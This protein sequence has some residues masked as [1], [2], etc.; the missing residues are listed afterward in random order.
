MTN[1]SDWSDSFEEMCRIGNLKA[2]RSFVS[3][4][5]V[6]S[7]YINGNSI[8]PIACRHGQL[9]VAEWF[10]KAFRLSVRSWIG[11]FSEACAVND[12][13]IIK[14]LVTKFNY[15]KQEYRKELLIH[16]GFATS[17]VLI[18][19]CIAHFQ[20]TRR[21]ICQ[22]NSLAEIM[23]REGELTVFHW[24]VITFEPSK[25]MI[26]AF[27]KSSFEAL[28][29]SGHEKVLQWLVDRYYLLPADVGR[30]YTHVNFDPSRKPMTDDEALE[31]MQVMPKW[32]IMR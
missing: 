4:Y 22:F 30:S 15:T 1:R 18:K 5:G 23:L 7:C 11:G 8:F 13:R 9:E 20:Y 19:W 21:E 29:Q 28:C 2:I 26:R 14:W 25:E 12:L 31:A 3:L 27:H 16:I 32:L 24:I 17:L 6:D 10:T